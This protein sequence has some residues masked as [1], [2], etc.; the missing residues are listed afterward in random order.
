MNSLDLLSRRML[1]FAI[2]LSALLLSGS[3]FVFS[4]QRLVADPAPTISTSEESIPA[5]CSVATTQ[6]GVYM[7]QFLGDQPKGV[8]R[9]DA[10]GWEYL[11][12][13]R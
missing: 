4:I 1:V 10:D 6:E 8:W 13:Q 9:A 11:E 5:N 12:Y 3:L 7:I 2:S